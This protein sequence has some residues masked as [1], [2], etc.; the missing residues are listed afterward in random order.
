VNII[1]AA[2]ASPWLRR[3]RNFC[4]ALIALLGVYALLG[5]LLVPSVAKSKIE[6]IVT[7]SGTPGRIRTHG[8]SERDGRCNQRF[9]MSA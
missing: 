6:T 4:I 1:A 2:V 8:G 3:L 9:G 5:F 7:A